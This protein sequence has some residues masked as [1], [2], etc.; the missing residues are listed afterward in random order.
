MSTDPLSAR[1]GDQAVLGPRSPRSAPHPWSA[2]PQARPDLSTRR[3][4][5]VDGGWDEP[6]GAQAAPAAAPGRS[7]MDIPDHLLPVLAQLLTGA[8]DVTAS[9]RLGMSPRTFSRRVSELLEH[10][11]VISR[12][13][14]GVAA[15]NQGW[16]S[17]R[18]LPHHTSNTEQ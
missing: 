2:R 14:A 1:G 8:T 15:A 7:V 4:S 18:H 13:Q 10:L 5:P 3:P 6:T 12:F 16:L 17:P 11:G 9:Q